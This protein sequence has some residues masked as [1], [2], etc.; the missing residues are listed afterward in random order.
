MH[1]VVY[2]LRITDDRDGWW[3]PRRAWVV[4]RWDDEMREWIEAYCSTAHVEPLAYW[5]AW[6]A[7]GGREPMYAVPGDRGI[8]KHELRYGLA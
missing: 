7:G 5:W 2:R 6:L 3:M 1:R 8:T 4:E